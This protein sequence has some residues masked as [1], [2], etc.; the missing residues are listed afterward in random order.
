MYAWVLGEPVIERALSFVPPHNASW[1][2]WN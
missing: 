2:D 1:F